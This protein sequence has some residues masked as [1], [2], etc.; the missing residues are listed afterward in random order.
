MVTTAARAWCIPLAIRCFQRQSL[1]LAG[2]AGELVIASED[3]CVESL[4]PSDDPRV[5]FTPTTPGISLGE[6]HN[7]A[8]QACHCQWIAKWDDDDWHAPRRLGLARRHLGMSQAA[9]AGTTEI[10]FHELIE[11]RRS[12]RYTYQG[13]RPWLGGNALM[14][15]REVW[16]RHPFPDRPSG[17]DTV[18]TMTALEHHLGVAIPDPGIVVV[19]QHGQTTGRKVWKPEPPEYAPLGA[20]L[21]LGGDRALYEDAYRMVG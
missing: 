17:V 9:L 7:Q 10:L 2:A 6:K 14:F 18:F 12:F 4:I 11:P 5:R 16:Q 20:A 19:L 13:D 1:L 15:R 3:E 8:V 21:D